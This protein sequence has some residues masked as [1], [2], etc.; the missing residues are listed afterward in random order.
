MPRRSQTGRDV[1]LFPRWKVHNTGDSP[2]PLDDVM[3]RRT[4]KYGHVNQARE[5][6]ATFKARW[7]ALP[8][9][10]GLAAKMAVQIRSRCGLSAMLTKLKMTKRSTG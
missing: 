5:H 6:L 10:S 4:D 8:P 2:E 9:G 1:R 3:T 7:M